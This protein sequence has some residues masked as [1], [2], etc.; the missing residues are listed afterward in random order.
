[1][2]KYIEKDKIV[3]EIIKEERKCKIAFK[4]KKYLNYE[5]IQFLKG[6]Y[7][8]LVNMLNFLNSLT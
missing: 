8:Q 5:K 3:K 1:M 2:S 6:E 7:R 4:N